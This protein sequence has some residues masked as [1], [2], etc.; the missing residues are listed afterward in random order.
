[1]IL[2]AWKWGW[3]CSIAIVGKVSFFHT[4]SIYLASFVVVPS[5]SKDLIANT[6]PTQFYNRVYEQFILEVY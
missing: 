1:M 3:W 5:L 6:T 4:Q 2:S